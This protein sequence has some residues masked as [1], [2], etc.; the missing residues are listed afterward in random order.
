MSVIYAKICPQHI[1]ATSFAILAG[2]NNF[3]S[4][5]SSWVGTW[6]NDTFVGVKED[7]LSK[8]W[9]LV[10]IQYV[11]CFLPLLL[12]W[13]IPT[14]KQIEELQDVIKQG[15]EEVKEKS[16]KKNDSKK[17]EIDDSESIKTSAGNKET[18][19][20]KDRKGSS[21]RNKVSK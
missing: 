18:R 1:E 15:Q 12:L 7:D 20:I 19:P 21:Q 3:S 16:K 14:R 6:I 9:V 2:I 4:T 10:T 8:Y 17:D 5:I 11:C 13:L